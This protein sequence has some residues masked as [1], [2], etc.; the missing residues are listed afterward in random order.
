MYLYILI[1][2]ATILKCPQKLT[3]NI[4]KKKKRLTARTL[5]I[6]RQ[7]KQ[8]EVENIF[9]ATRESTFVGGKLYCQQE[10]GQYDLMAQLEGGPLIQTTTS[11]WPL[12]RLEIIY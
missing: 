10:N 1:H 6:L 9:Q 11:H 3:I 2:C 4:L 7:R 12:G 5:G 8:F